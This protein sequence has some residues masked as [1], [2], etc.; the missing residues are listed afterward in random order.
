MRR[1]TARSTALTVSAALLATGLVAT[2][3]P[4]EARGTYGP[5]YGGGYYSSYGGGYGG[6]WRHRDRIDAGDVIGG[7]LLIGT[8]AAVASAASKAGERRERRYPDRY[9]DNRY[10]YPE[11]RGDSRG[12]GT[13]RGYDRAPAGQ[14]AAARAVDACAYAAEARAGTDARVERID[15]VRNLGN[16]A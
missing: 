10:P 6:R 9:P 11:Y 1:F 8:I 14:S 4:V 5:Y 15:G 12:Y 3:A 2:P 13:D 16:G 7:I